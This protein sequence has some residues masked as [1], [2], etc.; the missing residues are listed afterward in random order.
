MDVET[1]AERLRQMP[2]VLQL[3]RLIYE[4]RVRTGGGGASGVSSRAAKRRS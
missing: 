1:F 4:R 3:R 2:G